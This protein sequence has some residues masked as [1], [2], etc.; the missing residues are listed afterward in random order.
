MGEQVG[1]SRPV[2]GFKKNSLRGVKPASRKMNGKSQLSGGMKAIGA[3]ITPFGGPEQI[4]PPFF[5]LLPSLKYL[6]WH[7]IPARV[8]EA[9]PGINPQCCLPH[10]VDQFS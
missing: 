6:V 4:S 2:D 1:M 3:Q 7:A 9:L 5:L 8:E 10:H